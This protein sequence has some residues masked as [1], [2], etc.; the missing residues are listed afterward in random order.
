[1]IEG[2]SLLFR[3][4]RGYRHVRE[5]TH[6]LLEKGEPLSGEEEGRVRK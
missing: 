2:L 3:S 1:M 5:G 6:S 4:G